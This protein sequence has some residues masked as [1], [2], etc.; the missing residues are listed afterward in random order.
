[1]NVKEYVC[2]FSGIVHYHGFSNSRNS[3]YALDREEAPKLWDEEI[4]QQYINILHAMEIVNLYLIHLENTSCNA[5]FQVY[6]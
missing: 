2:T 5:I 6:L 3:S 4:V 1:V